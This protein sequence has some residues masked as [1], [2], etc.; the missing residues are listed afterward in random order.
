MEIQG[1]V[2]KVLEPTKYTSKK[3]GS[4]QYIYGFVIET[5]GQYARKVHMQVFGSERWSHFNLR[6]GVSGT[7]SFEAQSR[8]YK[9]RWFTELTC[10]NVSLAVSAASPSASASQPVVVNKEY[11]DARPA[12][13]VAEEQEDLP[14]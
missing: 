1:K 7:F 10:F 14:F 12:P 11:K 2:V 6:E 9:E 13:P 3:D 4:E 8:E 5:S